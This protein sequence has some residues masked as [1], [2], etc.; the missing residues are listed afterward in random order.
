MSL[1][2]RSYDGVGAILAVEGFH[3]RDGDVDAVDPMFRA[4]VRVFGLA[5]MSDNA[6]AGSAHG[7]RKY[8]LTD[9]GRRV[10]ARIDSLGGIVDLAHASD[11]TIDDVL[12]IPTRA[13]DGVPHRCRRDLPGPAQPLRRSVETHR[14][15]RRRNRDRFL[16]RRR[17][18]ERRRRHRARTVRTSTEVAGLDAMALGSDFDGAVRTPFD[19]AEMRSSRKRWCA[20]ASATKTIA[21]VMGLNALEFFLRALPTGV[22]PPGSVDGLTPSAQNVQ[23]QKA[24]PGVSAPVVVGRQRPVERIRATTRRARAPTRVRPTM[25]AATIRDQDGEVRRARAGPE[26]GPVAGTRR[27][28]GFDQQGRELAPDQR[29]R[30]RPPRTRACRRATPFR[31]PVSQDGS[32]ARRGRRPRGRCDR[33]GAPP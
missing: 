22:A 7:W 27:G 18:G 32:E 10:V 13:R 1:A 30:C 29:D 11:A 26:E 14:G 3:V 19:A 5:H 8:G 21:R 12:A 16:A 15:A 2:G 23:Y 6:V 25:I 17:C 20:P 28:T 31:T 33:P 24:A 4:G 9:F